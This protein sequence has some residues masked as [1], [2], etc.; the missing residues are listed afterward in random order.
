MPRLFEI[1]LVFL[2]LDV[3]SRRPQVGAELTLWSEADSEIVSSG[4]N[5]S[6]WLFSVGR[7]FALVGRELRRQL[8]MTRHFG[9]PQKAAVSAAPPAL[10]HYTFIP[11]RA[12]IR[13][14]M[15]GC[16]LNSFC[17][18][19]PAGC[20]PKGFVMKRC[21]VVVDARCIGAS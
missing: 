15:G 17:S 21:A 11:S 20:A 16:V 5:A 8:T 1:R 10:Y 3:A 4:R 2:D 9:S 7:F 6:L 14:G 18:H 19:C 13:S 12:A